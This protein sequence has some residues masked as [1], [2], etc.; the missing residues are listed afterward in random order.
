MRIIHIC[1]QIAFSKFKKKVFK[2]NQ[3]EKVSKAGSIHCDEKS[4]KQTLFFL[5]FK[6]KDI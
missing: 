1:Y 2:K 3:C 5:E 6:I 4:K